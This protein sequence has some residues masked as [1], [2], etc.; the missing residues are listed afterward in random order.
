[1]P[2]ATRIRTMPSLLGSDS[3]RAIQPCR[4]RTTTSSTAMATRR[5]RCTR[6]IQRRTLSAWPPLLRAVTLLTTPTSTA[7]P[8]ID[9][10]K[11]RPSSWAMAP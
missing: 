5:I 4:R 6:L 2:A 11:N 7:D 1:M 10:M 8:G 3:W 9:R